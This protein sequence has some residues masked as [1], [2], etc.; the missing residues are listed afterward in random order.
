MA[1]TKKPKEVIPPPD[2]LIAQAI[3]EGQTLI[4]KGKT[5]VEAAMGLLKEMQ[6]LTVTKAVIY[7]NIDKKAWE[8][9]AKQHQGTRV[10]VVLSMQRP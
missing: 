1:K 7:R 10:V 2:D 6:G 5:K 9:I 4:A 8:Q 3:A